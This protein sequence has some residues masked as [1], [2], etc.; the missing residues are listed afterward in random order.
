LLVAACGSS[1]PAPTPKPLEIGLLTAVSGSLAGLGKDYT[2]SM[3]LA[4]EE[5]NGNGGV[6]GGQQVKLLV[7]DEGTSQESAQVGFTKLV[8]QEHVLAVVGPEFSAGVLAI[9]DQIRSDKTLVIAP[10]TTSSAL[11]TLD[12]GGNFFRL[13]PSDSYQATVMAPLIAGAS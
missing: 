10:A 2:D 8:A 5:I 1:Q 9:A 13:S 4:F 12:S 11:T 6:V 7:Q 3:N